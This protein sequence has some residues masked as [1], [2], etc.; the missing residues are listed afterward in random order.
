MDFEIQP[1]L[2]FFHI[3]QRMPVI[4]ETEDRPGIFSLLQFSITLEHAM[5]SFL[6]ETATLGHVIT[7]NT[8]WTCFERETSLD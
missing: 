4:V 6:I 8:L 3:L 1:F 2:F 5:K 7:G